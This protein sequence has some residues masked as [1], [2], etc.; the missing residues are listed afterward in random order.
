[1]LSKFQHVGIS[2][3][4]MPLGRPKYRW[5]DDIRMYLKEIGINTRNWVHLPQDRNYWTALV[6]AALNLQVP[7]AM[8]LPLGCHRKNCL[9][10]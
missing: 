2:K 10:A 4:K 5:E 7:Q 1:M 6:N 3:E 8:V 9:F